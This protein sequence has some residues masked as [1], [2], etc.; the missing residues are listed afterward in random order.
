M[1]RESSAEFVEE[2]LKTIFAYALS[3]VSDK[4]DAEDLTN[5][6]VLAILQ[7][8][9]KIRNYNAFY[10]YVWGIAANT[11]RKFMRKKSRFSFDELDDNS[12]EEFDFTDNVLLRDDIQRLRREIALL[13]KEYR[14]CAVSYYYNELSCAEISEKFGISLEMVKYYLYKTRKILK[15]GICMEREFGEKSFKPAPFE[16]QT[17]FDGD[18]NREY[19]NLFSRKLPG[20]I[21][22]SAYYTP[23]TA[24]ELAI[25]LGVA[26]VYLED[27]IA[28]LEEYNLISKT[29]AGKYQTNLVIFTDDYTKEFSAKA[30]K[31]AEPVLKEILNCIREKLGEIRGLNGFCEKLSDNRLLWS[32]LWP[33]MRQGN[34]KFEKK[35]PQFQEKDMLYDGATGTN[36]GI[37]IDE[38]DDEFGCN[39][40]AGY[41][42]IDE[43]YYASAADFNVL[44]ANNKYFENV[45]RAALEEKIRRTVSG[46]IEP[47]FMILTEA[48][49]NSLFEILST[50]AEM[51]ADLYSQLFS[52][53]CRIM[54][55]HVPKELNKQA[56]GIV[57][58]TLFF[59]TVGLIG[60][61]AVKSKSLDIPDFDGP[62]AMYIRVKSAVKKDGIV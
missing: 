55:N 9:D 36:Y 56:D 28:V 1:I 51:M 19:C 50:E 38:F 43:N 13:S 11:Y 21:L 10:G 54:K 24:R 32:L 34:E 61:C 22:M 47:E 18:F 15:E 40:F 29:P 25:E 12:F 35:Y 59:R 46:E 2:N 44:P 53:A 3:R 39:S 8:S 4:N 57:F 58:R 26:T 27:E 49:E 20:Q 31:T 7:S 6:I 5:D 30:V 17:I 37:S 45:D 60:G 16:F 52:C 14:E 41:A 62:A 42:G 48:E 33:V 23:M